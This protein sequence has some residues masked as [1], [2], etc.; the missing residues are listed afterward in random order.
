MRR[1]VRKI[2]SDGAESRAAPSV[3][4]VSRKA[5]RQ[6]TTL[7]FRE[8]QPPKCPHKNKGAMPTESTAGLLMASLNQDASP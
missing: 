7:S 1:V 8:T 5:L 6:R 2:S 3:S 4:S